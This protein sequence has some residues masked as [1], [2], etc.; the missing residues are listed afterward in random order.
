LPKLSEFLL[1]HFD[2]LLMGLALEAKLLLEPM[3][4]EYVPG[5]H[6]RGERR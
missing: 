2:I 5:S 1:V 4:F 6:G 3:E